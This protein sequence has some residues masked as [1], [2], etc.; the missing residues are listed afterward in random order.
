MAQCWKQWTYRTINIIITMREDKKQLQSSFPP[1]GW[2]WNMAA[3]RF[4]VLDSGPP[5]LASPASGRGVTRGWPTAASVRMLSLSPCP[6]ATWTL[7]KEGRKLR[8]RSAVNIWVQPPFFSPL[9]TAGSAPRD[10]AVSTPMKSRCL[11][12][13]F[14]PLLSECHFSKMQPQSVGQVRLRPFV[15]FD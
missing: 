15:A 11:L 4:C 13:L 9:L 3:S 12:Q 5:S 6:H 7:A 2:I 10:T 8:R 1:G 14:L